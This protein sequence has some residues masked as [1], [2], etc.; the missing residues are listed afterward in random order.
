MKVVRKFSATINKNTCLKTPIP[1]LLSEHGTATSAFGQQAKTQLTAD[2]GC[3]EIL[4]RQ[5]SAHLLHN[6]SPFT[7]LHV[8][9]ANNQ[10]ITSVEKG[11]II[12]PTISG[13]I[14]LPAYVFD[15]SQ[16]SNNLA[17]LANF[18]NL[19]CTVT[20]TATSIII[21]RGDEIIWSGSKGMND[22]L[23]TLDMTHLCAGAPPS[24]IISNPRPILSCSALQ[25]IRHDTNAEFV[26]YV[27][28]VFASCPI[29]TFLHALRAGWLGNYPKITPLM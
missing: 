1:P 6:R 25:T 17:G 13:D 21:S 27:H 15:E 7:G 23:W 4:L 29:T 20:L 5:S 22:K 9:V 3:T 2:S 16:L 11:T 14:S 8:T 19:Q 24:A 18:T 10:I 28:A 26:A 12:I